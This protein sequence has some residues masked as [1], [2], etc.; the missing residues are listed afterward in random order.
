MVLSIRL[1]MH[2]NRMNFIYCNRVASSAHTHW[3]ASCYTKSLRWTILKFENWTFCSQ[4]LTLQNINIYPLFLTQKSDHE[5][6]HY[7]NALYWYRL[8]H[9]SHYQIAILL[10]DDIFF[11]WTNEL[12]KIH[13]RHMI[14]GDFLKIMRNKASRPKRTDKLNWKPK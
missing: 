10:V 6:Q 5:Y 14:F 4:V 12:N 7:K 13:M 8:Q 11:Q 3:C 9:T 1:L 2:E